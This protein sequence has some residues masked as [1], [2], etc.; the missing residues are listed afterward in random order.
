MRKEASKVKKDPFFELINLDKSLFHQS[1]L[2]P[3]R[4]AALFQHLYN[5]IWTLDG[6]RYLDVWTLDGRC[7]D[8]LCRLG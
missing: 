4:H 2:N 5:V 8:V 6:R 7:F 1:C 3:S